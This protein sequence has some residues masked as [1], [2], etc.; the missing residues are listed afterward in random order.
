M[1]MKVFEES[2]LISLLQQFPLFS[3]RYIVHIL[4]THSERSLKP[5]YKHYVIWVYLWYTTRI[6]EYLTVTIKSY[7][8][9]FQILVVMQYDLRNNVIKQIYYD[10][11]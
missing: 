6:G 10:Y 2:L 4:Y 9:F 1:Y 3:E 8:V 5:C 7:K 11:A